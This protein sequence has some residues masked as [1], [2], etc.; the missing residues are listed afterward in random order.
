MID[1]GVALGLPRATATELVTATVE[2][3]GGC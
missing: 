1:A 3:A 2:G